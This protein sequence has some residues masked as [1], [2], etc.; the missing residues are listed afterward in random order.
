MPE[1][2]I[3]LQELE[4]DDRGRQ[5]ELRLLCSKHRFLSKVMK[6]RQGIYTLICECQRGVGLPTKAMQP[7]MMTYPEKGN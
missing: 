4:C 7:A 3:E 6:R 2:T 1:E 5:L